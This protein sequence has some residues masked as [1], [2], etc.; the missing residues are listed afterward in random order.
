MLVSQDAISISNKVPIPIIGTLLLN[1][2]TQMT[3]KH[4]R[5]YYR[6]KTIFKKTNGKK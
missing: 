1:T 2:K 5:K 4:F 6:V 3:I